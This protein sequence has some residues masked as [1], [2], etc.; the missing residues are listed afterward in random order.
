MAES[1]RGSSRGGHRAA[2]AAFPASEG[3]R[4]LSRL[5]GRAS[6]RS[7]LP[8]LADEGQRQRLVEV[9]CAG[10]GGDV[11]VT[12][13]ERAEGGFSNETWFLDVLRADVSEQ[14]VLRRQALVGPLEPYDLGREAAIVEAL[15]GTAVP[16]PEVRLFCGDPVPIGSPFMVMS[17]IEGTVPEYR[18]LPELAAW[19]DPVNR[20]AMAREVVRMLALVQ[21]A[22]WERGR[23]AEAVGGSP[24]ERPPVLAK[25]RRILETLEWQVGAAA[26]PPV[27]R[28]TAAWLAE[29]P[30]AGDMDW[31]LVHGDWK[32]GNFI[33]R[34]EAIVAVLDWEEAGIGD[35]FEDL[36]YLC[37]PVM[38]SR[39]PE[40]M[41]MLVPLPELAAIYESELGR[42]LDLE[43]VH[44]YMIYAL[45]FHLYTLV[46]G[47]VSAVNGADLRV[48]LGYPKFQRATRELVVHMRAFEAGSHVL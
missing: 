29:N 3:Q 37:H 36:G 13:L 48:G 23:L 35:P 5:D 8:S 33:W 17:L 18:N 7:E 24:S 47:M 9:L 30:P 22:S 27:L 42:P 41:G 32:M 39:A 12:R 46:S 21:R 40:L 34:D 26:V 10:W 16:V 14:L 28:E 1:Y 11:E 43:R 2:P 31:V 45:Y 19:A 20:S 44:Y 15:A 6:D 38:R 25:V 4:P